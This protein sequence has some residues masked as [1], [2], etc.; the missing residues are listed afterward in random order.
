MPAYQWLIVH[1]DLDPV[2]GSEQRS[3]RPVLIVSRETFNQR[4]GNVSV[5]PLTST[6]RRL[7][8]SEVLL[9]AGKAGQPLESII[10]A[11][12]I[13]TISKER[14]QRQIGYLEDETLRQAVREALKTHLD[15][16]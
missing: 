13:R 10:L 15:L 16:D 8:P 5:V 2:R 9:P 1:A 12:Q 3:V 4:M 11:H 6:Q 14:L 7:Y